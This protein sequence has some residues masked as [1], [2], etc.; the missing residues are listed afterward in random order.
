[1]HIYVIYAAKPV[2]YYTEPF[3]HERSRFLLPIGIASATVSKLNLHTTIRDGLT[4][5]GRG[6]RPHPLFAY[7]R[8]GSILYS[9]MN[10]E[11]T[12]INSTLLAGEPLVWLCDYSQFAGGRGRPPENWA[13]AIQGGR[14]LA[15]LFRLN[16]PI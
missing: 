9:W 13:S 10:Y 7:T 15:I 5:R 8:C 16:K 3:S 12:A 4:E 2:Y 1:M 11:K 6:F 14:P